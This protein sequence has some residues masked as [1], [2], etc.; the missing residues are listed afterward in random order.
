MPR[1]APRKS[2]SGNPAAE[3]S[4]SVLSN[5]QKLLTVGIFAVGI[6]GDL[7]TV[8]IFRIFPVGIF[9][10]LPAMGA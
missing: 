10:L 7:R 9:P 1:R 8:G 5:F 4:W 3:R 2:A 6:F